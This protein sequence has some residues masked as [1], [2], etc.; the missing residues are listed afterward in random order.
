MRLL[1]RAWP[2]LLIMLLAGCASESNDE[3]ARV[4]V[5]LAN[6]TD[7][8]TIAVYY[9][10]HRERVRFLL[11]DTPE[12]SHPRHGEQP[13]GEEAK[14]F[15][16]ALVEGA[17]QLELEFDIG[18]NRDQYGRLLAY[19]YA[20]GIMIQEELLKNGLARVAYIFPPNTRYVD[21]FNALQ[22]DAQKAGIGIWEI[23][24]YAQEDGFYPEYIEGERGRK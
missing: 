8:D 1:F 16:S 21:Q 23:E 7:G 22:K 18:P 2:F 15:T 9:N 24:N 5:E 17:D 6:P 11:V 19:V 12:V 3:F 4:E 20:D 14:E 10:G 13:F